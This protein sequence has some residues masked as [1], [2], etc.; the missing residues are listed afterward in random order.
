MTHRTANRVPSL[1]DTLPQP[2][3]RPLL[4]IMLVAITTLFFAA[5]DTIGKEMAMKY[6]V[7]V[8]QAIRYLASTVLLFAFVY[9]KI[10]ARLWQTQKTKQVMFRGLLLSFASLTMGHALR[11]IPVGEAVSIL[12]LSPFAVMALAVPLFGEK[13]SPLGW[14]LAVLGFS[15]V[16]LVLRPGGGLDPVGVIYALVNAGIATAFHLMTRSL[17]KTESS[18]AML[19]YATINGAAF[20]VLTSI[21]HLSGPVPELFDI[22]LMVLMGLFATL[23]HFF[24]AAA[25]KIAPAS[26]VAPINYMHIVWAAVLGWLVFNHLPDRVSVFGM[27]L[28][29]VAGAA[30]ALNAHYVKGRTK[31]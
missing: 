6:P 29:I 22:G 14:F 1:T 18:I 17:S 5:A 19:F 7:P 16:L 20:F 10:G 26:L 30:L 13:V 25:Y 31:I 12:Y 24:F 3:Q 28:I 2:A 8:M 11:L 15:G 21:P 4:A 23:G 27:A 9:P